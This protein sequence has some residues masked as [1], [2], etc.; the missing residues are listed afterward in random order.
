MDSDRLLK[1]YIEKKGLKNTAERREVLDAI[2]KISGHFD[3]DNLLVYLKKLDLKIS[4]ASV[5]RTIPLF[6]DA[7][8][9]SESLQRDGR[10]VYEYGHEKSHHDHMI[11][12]KCGKLIEFSDPLIEKHQE[13]IC[14]KHKFKMTGHKLEIKGVCG[15]CV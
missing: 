13:E 6:V 10:T 4:R 1:N 5:Y 2:K 15:H 9:I 14:K 12:V 3:A 11:C 8:I 7:G